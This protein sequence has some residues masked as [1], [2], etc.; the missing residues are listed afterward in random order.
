MNHHETDSY[1]LS[2]LSLDPDLGLY[3]REVDLLCLEGLS[4]AINIIIVRLL[5]REY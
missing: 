5:F 4:L 1:S 2:H 3:S